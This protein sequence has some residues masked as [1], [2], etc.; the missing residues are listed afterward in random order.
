M[1]EP[2]HGDI[3]D[4]ARTRPPAP[5]GFDDPATRR[6]DDDEIADLGS[7]RTP[8]LLF[9]ATCGTTF[10]A[11]ALMEGSF[12]VASGIA[13]SATI[14]AILLA[15][16][17]GHFV[18]AKYHRVPVSLPYFIP[19]PPFVSL[20]TM[21]AV[22]RM[23]APIRNRDKLLDVAVGGPIAGMVVAVPLLIIGLQLSPIGPVT[24]GVTEGNSI[25][26]ALLKLLVHGEWLP[27]NGR[28]VQ[29][30]PMAFAAWVGFLI[31]MINLIPIGQ[32]DGGHVAKAVFGDRHE[33]FSGWL[34]RGLLVIGIG[35]SSYVTVSV[36]G[37]MPLIDSVVY[38]LS[39]GLP[40]LVWAVF[41]AVLRH[42][43]GG[44]YHPEVDSAPLT[45]GRRVLVAVV[46]V[47]FIVIFSPIPLRENLVPLLG[48]LP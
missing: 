24:G 48:D 21:G 47:L 19:L 8:V 29:L 35:V 33:A 42:L 9:L 14:M 31:T 15:H 45:R 46:F 5:A 16:E 27:A 38:G 32:L 39:A 22:I 37:F 18:I 10:A 26:Y 12:S 2:V 6:S 28:D 1:S 23:N 7:N 25:L 44:E 3:G 43:S 40:W 30:H 34:H 11:G 41:L 20:G 17:L 13:F 4:S 36:K